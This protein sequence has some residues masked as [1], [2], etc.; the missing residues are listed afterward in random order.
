M[1]A[2]SG[3]KGDHI[4]SQVSEST[5]MTLGAQ[6]KSHSADYHDYHRGTARHKASAEPQEFPTIRGTASVHPMPLKAQE[7]RKAQSFKYGRLK[8]RIPKPQERVHLAPSS[9]SAY[10]V[11]EAVNDPMNAYR[12]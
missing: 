8:E 1:K 3:G 12:K 9:G 10:P 5:P 7:G 11:C 4:G 2:S 6:L